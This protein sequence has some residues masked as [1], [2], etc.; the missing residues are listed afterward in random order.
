MEYIQIDTLYSESK[1]YNIKVNK[2]G[3]EMN[4]N[5]IIGLTIGGAI[6][7]IGIG[8]YFATRYHNQSK[9]GLNTANSK[10]NSD[11]FQK[12]GQYSFGLSVCN[13]MTKEKVGEVIGLAITKTKDYSNNTSTGCEYYVGNH[14]VIIDVI[15]S[16][17]E[18]QKKGLEALGYKLT[19][20]KSIEFE[21]FIQNSDKPES[22]GQYVDIYMIVDPTLKLV[23]VGRS[24]TAIIDNPTLVKLAKAVEEK[25]RSYK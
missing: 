8:A 23:R 20:D 14:F 1:D 17:T 3:K 19:S 12:T 9:E 10:G 16:E 18:K 2:L 6:L 25:I 22:L 13:E 21:N 15:F 4:K 24:D 7:V 11:D 5:I